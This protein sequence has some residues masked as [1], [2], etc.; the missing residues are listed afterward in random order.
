MV[1][2]GRFE[3]VGTDIRRA[4]AAIIEG[5][6]STKASVEIRPGQAGLSVRVENLPPTHRGDTAEVWLAILE[7]DLSIDVSRGE[8]AGRRLAH[9]GVVRSLTVIGKAD[10]RGSPAFPGERA[11]K[12]EKGWRMDN[13]RAVIF[14][15]ERSGR[16]VLGAAATALRP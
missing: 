12:V 13:L 15:Q 3:F 16:R 7:D 1:M 5:S 10:A 9:R 4:G 11:I 6:R 2:D 8:N 14:V